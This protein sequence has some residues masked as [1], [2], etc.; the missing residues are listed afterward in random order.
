TDNA[1]NAEAV[2]VAV[3]ASGQAVAVW[4]QSDGTTINIY[5]N[6]YAPAVGWGTPQ[7]ISPV[8][9]ETS[10]APQVAID[11]NGNA[12]AVWVMS[13]FAQSSSSNDVWASRYTP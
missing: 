4:Q 11:S 10:Q 5:A 12:V 3:N 13:N 6:R 7:R 8:V 2:Q 9:L 1:G